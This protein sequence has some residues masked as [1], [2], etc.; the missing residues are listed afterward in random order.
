VDDGPDGG[1]NNGIQV[2]KHD[3]QVAKLHEITYLMTTTKM[4]VLTLEQ[5][6]MVDTTT[7]LLLELL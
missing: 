6:N 7:K 3:V 1:I 2:V 5:Y 4:E